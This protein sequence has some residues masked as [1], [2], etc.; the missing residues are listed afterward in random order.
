MPENALESEGG[1]RCE[2]VVGGD[3]GIGILVSSKVF[4]RS[5]SSARPRKDL[6]GQGTSVCVAS[7]T[8]LVAGGT[9][10]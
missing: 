9:G 2:F 5:M 10:V 7:N 6:P 1:I 4:R 8:D 3:K